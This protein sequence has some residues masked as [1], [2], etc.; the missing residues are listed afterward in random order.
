MKVSVKKSTEKS[1]SL[2]NFT[3]MKT[4]QYTGLFLVAIG[5]IHTLFAAI[6][7]WP[8]V[9]GMVVDGII[10]SVSDEPQ[11]RFAVHWF[12]LSGY[13]WVVTGLLCHWMIGQTRTPLPAF[14]GVLII[15]FGLIAVGFQ[16]LSGAWVFIGLGG[17][18]VYSA[19]KRTA[20]GVS[21]E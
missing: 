20:V 4:W 10:N 15:V 12:M 19:R 5:V 14:F 11:S 8:F 7:F 3:K 18:I 21:S 2:V 17:Y 1:F 9:K 13:F 6:V 16:P